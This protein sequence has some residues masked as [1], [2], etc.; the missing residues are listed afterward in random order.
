MRLVFYFVP[1]VPGGAVGY[2]EREVIPDM[3]CTGV[4]GY[5]FEQIAD[6]G[7]PFSYIKAMGVGKV[8]EQGYSYMLVVEDK[9]KDNALSMWQAYF[10]DRIN[11]VKSQISKLEDKKKF[12]ENCGLF[13][14]ELNN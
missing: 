5:S 9:D 3:G 2:V 14:K 6:Q 8:F 4:I 7:R 12:V 13:T 10:N 1:R 11:Q